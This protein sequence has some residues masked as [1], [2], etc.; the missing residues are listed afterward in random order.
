MLF[1][2][3]PAFL[4][5]A[6]AWVASAWKVRS[7]LSASPAAAT[8]LAALGLSCALA[9]VSLDSWF[10]DN[11]AREFIEWRQRLVLATEIGGWLAIFVLPSTVGLRALLRAARSAAARQA[12]MYG[13]T[14]SFPR[15]ITTILE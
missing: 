5:A 8:I 6:A 10:E 4:A 3:P 2:F 13:Q 9:L 1:L 14:N 11:G 12:S 7:L 15:R